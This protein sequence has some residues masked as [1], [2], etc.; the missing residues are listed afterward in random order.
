LPAVIE[1]LRALNEL[2]AQ[3]SVPAVQVI[4]VVILVIALV[5][6]EAWTRTH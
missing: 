1:R 4:V 6:I 3:N 2:L 5:R